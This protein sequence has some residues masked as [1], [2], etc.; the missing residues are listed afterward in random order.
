MYHIRFLDV[1]GQLSHRIF[2]TSLLTCMHRYE[3]DLLWRALE[4]SHLKP[5]VSTLDGGLEAKVA[6]GGTCA[7][8]SIQSNYIR[9]A[10]SRM[11]DVNGLI[12][13]VCY[14]CYAC[15]RELQCR[16]ATTDLSRSCASS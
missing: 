2:M 8:M 12:V 14:V 13:I 1:V 6:E 5:Y 15:R 3:D 10:R 9:P 11:H 7:C 16:T 4:V